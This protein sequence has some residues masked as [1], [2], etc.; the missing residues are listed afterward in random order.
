M[1]LNVITTKKFRIT[2]KISAKIIH[3]LR[4]FCIEVVSTM[5]EQ[6]SGNIPQTKQ[7]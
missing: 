6:N 1:I 2:K 3:S 7:G 5:R 4:L